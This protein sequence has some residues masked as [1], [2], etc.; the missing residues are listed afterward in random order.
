MKRG[1]TRR[2]FVAVVTSAAFFWTLTLSVSPQLHERL[3]PDSNRTDHSCAVTFV[4]SGNF[5]HSPVTLLISAPV[6]TDEF[7]IPELTPLWVQPLFLLA[8]VFE[9]APPANS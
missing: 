9:H 6:P 4:A 2:A 5:N 8:S 7:K 1:T 3:H